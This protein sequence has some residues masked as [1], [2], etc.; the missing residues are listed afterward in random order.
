MAPGEPIL[1]ICHGFPPVPGIG[2]RRWAKFAKELARRGHPVHV[3]RSTGPKHGPISLWAPDVQHPNII[4]H[5]LPQRYPTVLMKQPLDRFLDKVMYRAWLRLLPLLTQGNWYDRT[6]FWRKQLLREAEKII[7]KH[8]IR[9][10]IVT[11]APFSLM[12]YATGL[13]HRFPEVNL[14]A[15]LRDPWTWGSHYGHNSIGPVRME[16]ERANEVL[17]TTTF[18]KLIA[19]SASVIDHLQRSHGSGTERYIL[20]PHTID[21]DESAP[22][23]E[24]RTPDGLFRMVYAGSLYDREETGR[25]FRELFRVFRR[26]RHERPSAFPDCRLDLYITGQG[27]NELHRKAQEQDLQDMI[28]FHEPV[29]PKEV[30]RQIAAADLVLAFTSID[31]KDIMVTKF[32]EIF[33]LRRPV[34]HIGEPGLVSRTIVE[35]RLGDSLRVE[36]LATELPR[37]ISGERKIEIDREADHS[38]YLLGPITD[39]LVREVLI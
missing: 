12:T 34:L 23:A 8:G 29:S 11:G 10:V 32:N 19:P 37:I 16:R 30:L 25:Y 28:H 39:R 4:A 7:A 24:T 21:P 26:M 15:D 13:K 6:I 3:I 31:K 1:I 33:H 2:G 9:N 5:P 36:E 22:L 38:E 17:V 20:L 18:A 27:A 14:V 35:R